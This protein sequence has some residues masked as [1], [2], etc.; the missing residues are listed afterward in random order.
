MEWSPLEIAAVVFT[1]V[2]VWLAIKE[3]M[4]TWPTGIA[5]VILYAVVFYQSRLYANAGLQVIYFVL[6]IHGWYEWLHGGANKSEL[7]VRRTTR[8]QWIGCIIAGV[9][10]TAALM[11][12]LKVVSGSAPFSDAV[13]TAFSIVGQWMLNE[14]LLENWLIWLAVDIIYVPLFAFSH[15]NLSALLYALFCVLCVKGIIDWKRSLA[16]SA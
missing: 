13:T 7:H 8:R 9:V 5:S 14:K 10:L 11:W 1:L 3:N 6:S 2:N 15:R 16:A 12:L 4:W